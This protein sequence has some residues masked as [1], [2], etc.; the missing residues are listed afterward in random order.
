MVQEIKDITIIGG[1]PAGLFALFYAGMREVSAQIVD[2][3]PEAGGQLTALYPEKYIFDVAGIPQVLAKDLVRSLVAQAGRFQEPIHLTQRVVGLEQDGKEFVLVTDRDR[4]PTRA[5][6]IAAGIG[7][8]SPRRLPQRC[9]EPWYGR[10]I[11]DV[12]TDPEQF[13]DR[14]VLIIGGGDSAFDW[15]TQL[16]SRASRVTVVHRSDRFRA[17]GATVAEFQAAVKA[18]RAE[19]YTFHE[20]QDI[21]CRNGSDR[22]SHILLRDIKAKSTREIEVDVVLPMLGFVSNMGAIGEWGLTIENDEIHVNS[23]METGR[24]GIYAAGDVTTYPGKLK[25]I[26]TGF[27]EAATAVNQAVHWIHPEKKIAPGHSS[28]MGLFGQKDD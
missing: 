26:A 11:Y 24:P 7:A 9:A 27:G 18:D 12:V 5:I 3:L 17:H 23:Q 20:L 28:N 1:G 13:R 2:A 21:T 25:L 8:F 19:L 15:G 14:R 16:L 6:V 22:F 10:G 4:F